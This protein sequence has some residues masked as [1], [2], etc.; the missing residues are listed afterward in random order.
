[1]NKRE[2]LRTSMIFGAGAALTPHL[3]S[4]C[5][6][7]AGANGAT[8]SLVLT[9]DAGKFVQPEL[10]Y[11]YDA[12][13]PHID[14]MTMELHY[15]KHHAGYTRKF[16]D[17]LESE[18]LH[19]TDIQNIF[20]RVST[21]SDG[22][23]NNGG[24]YYNHNLFWKFMSPDGGGEPGG[25][26]ATAINETFG[27]FEQFRD[28]FSSTAGS[29][30]GSGWAWLIL[31]DEGNLQVVSTPNQDNPLMDVT[32]VNGK[33]LLNIDVWE[34]AYYLKYQNERGKYIDAYWNVI[35]WDF[36]DRLYREATG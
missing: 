11:A 20:S 32:D 6:N 28:L 12:L 13:V 29:V 23:R 2:F 31:N 19:S 25:E 34:H 21:L 4:S 9:D 17:A 27:S 3:A 7:T 15:S 5:M 24:G 14:A 22:V 18:N 26:I 1:M 35:D 10:G 16:N 30:F 36:V 8:A 33:P